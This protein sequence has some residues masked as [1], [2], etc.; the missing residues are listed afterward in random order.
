[1]LCRSDVSYDDSILT[2]SL[3]AVKVFYSLSSPRFNPAPVVPPPAPRPAPS[4]YSASF[5]ATLDPSLAPPIPPEPLPSPPIQQEQQAPTYTCL[6]RLSAP[7]W[8][9]L[10]GG[11]N[12][13]SPIGRSEYGKLTLKTCLSAICIS[14]YAPFS[15]AHPTRIDACPCPDLSL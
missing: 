11:G 5:L 4:T 12:S 14:R 3:P 7:V 8:V 6:A 9:Q 13:A 15:L 1:M 2:Y 10:L